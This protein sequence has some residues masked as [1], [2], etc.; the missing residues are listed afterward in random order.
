M[1]DLIR[2]LSNAYG[3]SGFEDEVL[4]VVEKYKGQ[5]RMDVDKLMNCYLSSENQSSKEITLMLDAH[6]DE[7]GFMVQFIDQQGLIEFLPLGRWVVENIPSQLVMVR[8]SEGQYYQGVVASKAPHFMTEAEREQSLTVESLKIDLGATS[9]QEVI[10]DFKIQVG[11]PIV[12]FSEFQFNQANQMM[13]GK[14]FDNRL[15]CAAVI[16]T[17]KGLE[18]LDLD[19]NVVGALAAQEEVGTRGAVVTSRTVRPDLAIVFEGSPS[20]DTFTDIYHSQCRI[21]A[22]P[23]FRH[24]DNSYVANHRFISYGEKIARENQIPFQ[25]T[26]RVGGGTNAG[27]IHL[28]GEGVPTLVLGIP[29]RYIHS[30]HGYAGLEDFKNT[31]RLAIEIIKDLDVEKYK[32]L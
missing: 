9:R 6:L 21:K 32:L 3:T 24:R 1:L 30:H 18:D 8:N 28:S 22:G 19:I 10:E 29:V 16:E 11:A 7:V 17:L 4:T 25:N 14:A 12:P 13:L 20:D 26:V 5:L 23:Q 27:R 2:D 15:G 31:V